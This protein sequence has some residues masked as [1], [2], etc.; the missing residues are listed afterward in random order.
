MASSLS[1]NS[2]RRFGLSVLAIARAPSVL[3][4][5]VQ[6]R[7]E[8]LLAGQLGVDPQRQGQHSSIRMGKDTAFLREQNEN[9]R[10]AMPQMAR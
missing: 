2:L 1:R 5:A 8:G 9:I 10:K 7:P 6:R 3:G 4:V